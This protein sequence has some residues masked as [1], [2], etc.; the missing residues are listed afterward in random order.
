MD[1][2]DDRRMVFRPSKPP[3]KKLLSRQCLHY[4][5]HLLLVQQDQHDADDVHVYSLFYRYDSIGRVMA[6]TDPMAAPKNLLTMAWGIVWSTAIFQ[7]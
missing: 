1:A 7:A 4:S 5:E 2:R 3:R 6:K